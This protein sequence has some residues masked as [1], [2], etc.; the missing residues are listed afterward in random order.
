VRA[1][2]TRL[3]VWS[4]AAFFGSLFVCIG[5]HP[6]YLF[7]R[8]EGGL[9]NFGV[10]ATTVVP[11]TVAFAGSAWLLAAASRQIPR[12]TPVARRLAGVLTAV[13][14]VLGCVLV[15]TYPYQHGVVLRDLHFAT[16]AVAV[17][18]EA[19]A[20]AWFVAAVSRGPID[21]ALLCLEAVGVA[22][23]VVTV[24]GVVH[25]LFVSQ[26]VVAG[27]FGALSVRA[28]ATVERARAGPT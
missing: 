15:T 27:A 7:S 11:F 16:G 1:E 20:S 23:S 4:Q 26:L 18:V 13:A 17:C 14:V 25:A 28:T 8:N 24:L 19:V 10:H 2:F 3:V 12:S 9:S 21:V 5:L 6:G 22:L